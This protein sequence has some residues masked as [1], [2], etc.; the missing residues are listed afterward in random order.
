MKINEAN[1]TYS[2]I[3]SIGENISRL[4]KETGV[5]YL[6]LHRGVMDVTTIDLSKINLDLNTKS[7]Q[8]YSENDGYKPLVETIKEEFDLKDSYLILTP[9]GMAGLDIVIN[10]LSNK[11]IHIPKYHWGSWNK[12]LKTHFKEIVLIDDFNLLNN[13]IINGCVMLCFPSNPT[14]YIPNY[15]ILE[16]YINNCHQNNT[17]VIL[18]IP[19]YHLINIGNEI[20]KLFYDN[21]IVISSFSKSLGL[22]GFRVGYVATKNKKLY[23]TLKIRSLYKY[24]SI[25]N[26]SQYIINDLLKNLKIEIFNYKSETMNHIRKNINYL[27]SNGLLSNIYPEPPMGPFAIINKDYHTLLA[28][29]ISSV[30]LSKFTINPNEFD[31]SQSRISVSINHDLFVEYFDKLKT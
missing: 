10:S 15:E 22:S 12:I 19:Y 7:L 31:E 13:K 1:V 5:K 9:G 14:G 18:D 27:V 3:V 17:T 29:K 2:S 28:N 30:P 23:E 6:K 16:S 25:S 26:P 11:H 8:Q 21:V 24:N 20:S 4:E